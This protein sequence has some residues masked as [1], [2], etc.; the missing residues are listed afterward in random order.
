M[1]K[2]AENDVLVRAER[3]VV[4]SLDKARRSREPKK[5]EAELRAFIFG[6]PVENVEGK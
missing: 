1:T 3:K 6:T 4:N 5:T 2:N